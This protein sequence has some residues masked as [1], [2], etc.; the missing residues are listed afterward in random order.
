MK[1]ESP[2]ANKKMYLKISMCF[3]S[4]TEHVFRE[5][6]YYVCVVDGFYMFAVYFEEWSACLSYLEFGRLTSGETDVL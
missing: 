1:V 3:V 4:C 6:W 5:I 2:T